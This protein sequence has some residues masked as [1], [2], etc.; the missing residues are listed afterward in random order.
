ME[1]GGVEIDRDFDCYDMMTACVP[2]LELN[3][4]IQLYLNSGKFLGKGLKTNCGKF[5]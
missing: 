5:H 4:G 2:S 1:W 3:L